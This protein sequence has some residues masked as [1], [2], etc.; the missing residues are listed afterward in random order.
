MAHDIFVSHSSKDKAIADAVCH[1]LEAAGLKCWI[2][3]RDVP[4][5]ADWAETIVHAVDNCQVMVLVFSA[6][7]SESRQVK[8]EL[9]N[10]A[11]REKIIIPLRIDSTVL[12]DSFA[13]FLED[14]HWLDAITPPIE[15]HLATLAARIKSL[16]AVEAPV[17]PAR[18]APAAQ[19]AAPGRA[20]LMAAIE[21]DDASSV[22][23]LL[24]QGADSNANDE[25]GKTP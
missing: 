17:P 7:S 2:A 1:H 25:Y 14:T 24:E 13:F 9:V 6:A 19:G 11:N 8:R 23:A 3:P 20:A 5:G 18:S 22:K 16:L 10:A 4:A 12:K 15:Q 21:S